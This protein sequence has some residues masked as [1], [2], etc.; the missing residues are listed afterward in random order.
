ME[1]DDYY[2]TANPLVYDLLKNNAKRMRRGQTE[3]ESFLWSY[4]RANQ[5]GIHFR[6]Q[7]PIGIFIA[8]FICIDQR[9]IIEVD[10]NIHNK[11]EQQEWDKQRT[12]FLESQDYRVVRF[13]N[14][15][16]LHD[17]DKVLAHIK[18]YIIK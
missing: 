5:L 10:G 11:P 18:S 9:L 16:V 3:A 7:H 12:A 8:D 17:I 15:Q 14:E 2:K 13:S 1:S 6:R 4:I